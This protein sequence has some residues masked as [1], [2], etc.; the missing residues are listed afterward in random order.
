[1]PQKRLYR[2][3]AVYAV[4]ARSIVFKFWPDWRCGARHTTLPDETPDLAFVS[5]QF[6]VHYIY[7]HGQAR[8][9][10]FITEE[11]IIR[12]ISSGKAVLGSG[13][14][15]RPCQRGRA[16]RQSGLLEAV[17]AALVLLGIVI[18]TRS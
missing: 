8:A 3:T 11:E 9:H 10:H 13:L 7:A 16:R 5:T 14:N 15:L 4:A 17:L 18:Q 1:M 6:W 2:I 12:V